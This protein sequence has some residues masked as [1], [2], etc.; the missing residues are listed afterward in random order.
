MME[1]QYTNLGGVESLWNSHTVQGS[2]AAQAAVRY[3]QVAVT[4]GTVAAT[5]TQ[6]AT[7]NPDA[8]LNRFMPSLAVDCGGDMALGYTTSNSTSFP[9]IGYAGR[10]STDPLTSLP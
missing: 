3:Y 7:H 5:T 2:S 6:A 10:L 1:N 4:G 9:A 8:V